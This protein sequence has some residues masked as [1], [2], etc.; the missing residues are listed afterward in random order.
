[1]QFELNKTYSGFRLVKEKK[2]KEIN[3]TLRLFE[4]LKSGARLLNVEN[5]DDNKVFSISFR[6][7]PKDSTGTPHILEHSVLCGSRKFPSKEPF[8]DLIK[9]SLNTFLNA[10]TFSDKTMYPV[11]SKNEKDFFNLMDVYLD[12]ALYPNIYKIKEIFMQEGW[13]YE[14]NKKEDNLTYKGVVFNEMQGAFSQPESILMRKIQQYLFPDTPYG[15]ESGGDP[16]IIPQLSWE[17]FLAFHK[18]Y[19]HPS[20][21]YIYLYGNGNLMEELKFID[22]KYLK[23][24]D[25]I[26][27][28]SKIPEQKPFDSMK[29][30][31]ENY[32]ITPDE[33]EIDKAYLSMSFVTG[34]STN[35]EEYLALSILEHLLLDTEAAPLRKALI[36]AGIGKDVFGMFDSSIYQPTF[37]IVV[38]NSNADKKEE[39]KKVVFN[40]LHRLVKDGIDKKLI[41]ASINVKE[42][43]LREA[44]EPGI[45]KGLLFDIKLMDSWLHDEDPAMHLSYESTLNKI[46]EGSKGDYFEKLIQKYLLD[47]KHSLLLTLKPQK[48]LLES[49]AKEVSKKLSDYKESLSSSQIDEIIRNTQKLK[50]R[51]SE[52]DSPEDAA[53]IPMLAIEDINKKTEKIAYDVKDVSGVKVLYHPEFTN[54][55]SYISL[56]F[57]TECIPD[58]LL[59]YAGLLANIIGKSSTEKY[60]Y[61]DLSKEININ[62]GGIRAAIAAYEVRR[63]DEDFHPEF[64]IKSKVLTQK[65]P[66]LMNILTE[67]TG[68]L[69]LDEKKRMKEIIQEI[70]SRLEMSIFDRGHAVVSKRVFSYFSPVEN[71]VETTSGLSYYK[72]VSG[73]EKHFDE[74]I[75]EVISN[76]QKV[77]DLVFNKDNLLIGITCSDDDYGCFEENIRTLIDGLKNDS[78]RKEKCSFKASKENEGLLTPG[79]VQYVAKGFNYKRLGYNY[80]G[81]MQVLKTIISLDYL[82]NRVRV[83][84][85]AYGGFAYVNRDGNVAFASYRDPNLVDTLNVYNEVSAFI[86]NFSADKKEM[87]KYIIG[88]IG[89]L[90]TPLSPSM[91]GDRAIEQ[92]LGKISDDEI[93]NERDEILS[94]TDEDIRKFAQ[95]FADVMKQNY[96]CVLGNELKIKD[97]KE[98]F[99]K[100]VNVFE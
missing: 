53:K 97:N 18:K 5:D 88:T 96:I 32:P 70:K 100:L 46:K 74:R 75:D 37:G 11:A 9:G 59:P 35:P 63:N 40:T 60:N 86:K 2:V 54:K 77:S 71:Y 90:D 31:V 27:V 87:T 30:I 23:D 66:E 48:G 50:K 95:L 3:S 20:N 57:N 4:H 81:K 29:D 93:Q 92:Y 72:F 76:L 41:E 78:S 45:P 21:S 73:I 69:K 24:F 56:L 52:P 36:D 44:E 25:R 38:K 6:T 13:H 28:D 62:T 49:R 79:N 34:K 85:G 1:M 42:F 8:V 67:L 83:Q 15:F 61:E 94:T 91:K 14:L 64:F 98:I 19:Y 68:K 22:G 17:N 47:N 10:F 51:Q 55:I 43:E 39:L 7:P 58:E 84:G 89:D 33:S 65:M 16:D 80:S 99:N 12:A 82:W 26:N